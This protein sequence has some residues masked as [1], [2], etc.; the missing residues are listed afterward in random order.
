MNTISIAPDLWHLPT[1]QKAVVKMGLYKYPV[2]FRD[3]FMDNQYST[4]ELIVMFKVQYK[5]LACGT[6]CKNNKGWD[7]STTNLL[8]SATRGKSKCH[9]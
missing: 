3:L 7:Q 8:K 5:I 6:I 1:T 2:E 4:P 9:F